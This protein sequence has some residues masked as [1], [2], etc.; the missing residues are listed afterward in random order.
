MLPSASDPDL[1]RIL[2]N[3]GEWFCPPGRWFGMV[4]AWY[5][6]SAAAPAVE[7]QMSALRRPE[8]G[9]LSGQLAERARLRGL[10]D[11]FRE[12]IFPA[13]ASGTT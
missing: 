7:Y 9:L 10:I 8:G 2:I 3:P 1:Y 11:F 5:L 4:Y 6:R 12:E 13:G